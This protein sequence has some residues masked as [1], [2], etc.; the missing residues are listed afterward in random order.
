M[1]NASY[2]SSPWLSM[3]DQHSTEGHLVLDSELV[4]KYE[5]YFINVGKFDSGSFKH[6]DIELNGIYEE[7]SPPDFVLEL[8]QKLDSKPGVV[9]EVRN[10]LDLSVCLSIL[11]VN[12][13]A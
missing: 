10:L 2:I 1:V 8:E 6:S 7:W 9:H 3:S 12:V 4:K 13:G 5:A 11:I